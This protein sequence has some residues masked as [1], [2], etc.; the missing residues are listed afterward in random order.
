MECRKAGK[1]EGWGEGGWK[2]EGMEDWGTEGLDAKK[3]TALKL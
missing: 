2:A 1:M 3:G